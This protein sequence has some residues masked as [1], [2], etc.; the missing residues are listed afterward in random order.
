MFNTSSNKT[1]D[2]CDNDNV[3]QNDDDDDSDDHDDENDDDDDDTDHYNYM[4]TVSNMLVNLRDGS[5]QTTVRAA[6]LR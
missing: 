2:V 4:V 1:D 5:A 6:T 3:D